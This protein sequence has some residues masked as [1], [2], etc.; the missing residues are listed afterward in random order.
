[1][2]RF[3]DRFQK[4]YQST[5]GTLEV[6]AFDAA[7]TLIETLSQHNITNRSELRDQIINTSKYSGI[8]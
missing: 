3:I 5:P 6:Q 4:E 8:S 7:N 2:K 1:M